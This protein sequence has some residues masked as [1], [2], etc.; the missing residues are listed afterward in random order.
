[1]NLVFWAAW[2]LAATLLTVQV[3]MA[4][5]NLATPPN[6]PWR[7]ECGSCH[8]AYPPQLLP[9]Q[10]WRRLMGGLDRH[11]GT[12]A[13]VEAP[14]R[15]EITAYLERHAGSGKRVAGAGDTLRI[16]QTPW[17]RREHDEVALKNPADCAACH[18]TADQGDYRERNLRRPR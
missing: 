3:A 11:F 15:A 16:T 6:E 17:F 8:V 5:G 13:S 14:L 2:T 7:A 10:S 4:K 18:T 12:D 1:M 9:A